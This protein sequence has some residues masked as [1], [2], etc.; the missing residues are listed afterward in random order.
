MNNMA[1]LW[2]QTALEIERSFEL[3][4]QD[5]PGEVPHAR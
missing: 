5:A 4:D 1:K 3:I 2:M